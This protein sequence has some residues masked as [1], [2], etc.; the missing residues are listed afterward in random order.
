MIVPLKNV[1]K[2][3]KP[4]PMV[5]SMKRKRNPLGEITK[6]E[7][8]LCAGG[9]KYIEIVDYWST[10][11]PVVPWQT[12]RLVLI[13]ALIKNWHIRSVDFV[14]AYLQANIKTDI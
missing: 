11:S 1:P 10:Y 9:H 6:W 7:A 14:M 13:L 4:I 5:W 2:H 3:K 12:I 8:R